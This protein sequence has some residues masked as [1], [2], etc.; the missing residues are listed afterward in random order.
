MIRK[1][2]KKIIDFLA[3]LEDFQKKLW[4]KKKF[5]VET[6]YCITLDRVPEEFYAEIATN[7][8]QVEEWVKL[9]AIDEIKATAGD[10][11]DAGKPGYS[12]PLTV[13]FLK[14]NDKLVLDTKFFSD[15][16]KAKLIGGIENFDE[17]MDGLLIHSENFQA[18][19]LLQA[20]YREQVKC[21][22]IDPP[23]NTAA[24]EI[25]Y[26]NEYRH[27]S[28]LS[29]MSDRIISGKKLMSNDSNIQVAIDDAEGFG[30]KLLMDDL[31][32]ALNYVAT[33]A[34]QHNPRGRAD[35]LHISP[36]HEYLHIYA[37]DY[38]NLASNQLIQTEDE[39]GQKYKKFDGDS[40][41][42]ELPF[43]RSGSNSKRADRP[44]LFYPLYYSEVNNEL[45]LEMK[46]ETF[47][48][49]L[50][51]D[52]NGE[53][54]VWRWGREKK[55]HHFSQPNLLSKSTEGLHS[56]VKDRVKNTV[57]PKSFWYGA[58]YDASSHGTMLL[59]HM[60]EYPDF[61]YP[62]SINAVLDSLRIGSSE[63]DIILDYFGGSGTTAAGVIS[64]NR[65]DIESNRQFIIVE[66]GSHFDSSLLPRTKKV[67]Y[68]SDWKD[69]KPTARDTGISHCFK[70]LR[71]ESY[72][73]TLNNLDLRRTKEQA[74]LLD[75]N[76]V[77]EDK[78]K[79]LHSN[80]IA[81]W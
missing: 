53:E 67:I 27:S 32:G 21:V 31:Y 12:I 68:S 56:Y 18:L 1:V 3:Q 72:E 63:S 44:N 80:D 16:F 26:K 50:P 69:G 15:E 40:A 78:L 17:Q 79:Q 8:A 4:L 7:K 6:N 60:F 24:S 10:L 20:R 55:L 42:R 30:L 65:E 54:R 57:K 74:A 41:F 51:L 81:G 5:V 73:D 23:Y 39:L 34:I 22:Y 47:V 70:Y 13:A 64:L 52:S 14:A 48:E 61:N 38:S 35:A 46:D 71:L 66:M 2:A 77:G 11:I 58:K 45:S 75:F 49:I 25:L 76:G 59:K 37:N 29:L 19:N 62:K 28:W 36:S 9:F 43:K 33:I